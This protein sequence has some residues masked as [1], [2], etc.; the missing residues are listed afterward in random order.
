MLSLIK[1]QYQRDITR[2]FN[3]V[4]GTVYSY[5]KRMNKNKQIVCKS[6]TSSDKEIIAV[7]NNNVTANNPLESL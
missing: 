7:L 3:V 4:P 1:G 2:F 5:F 6:P